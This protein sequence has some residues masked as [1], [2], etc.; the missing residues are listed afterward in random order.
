MVK[1]DK[2]KRKDHLIAVW[3][4]DKWRR[5]LRETFD[6]PLHIGITKGKLTLVYCKLDIGICNIIGYFECKGNLL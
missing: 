5:D 4:A 3:T 2:M 1:C 6:I